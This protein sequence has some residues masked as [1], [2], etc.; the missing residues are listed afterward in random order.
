MQVDAVKGGW[1]GKKGTGKGR[2]KH[3]GRSSTS[4]K[5]TKAVIDF[6]LS[7]PNSSE[8]IRPKLANSYSSMMIRD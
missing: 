6:L 5:M 7:T 3:M 4:D 8:M 2:S 1:K